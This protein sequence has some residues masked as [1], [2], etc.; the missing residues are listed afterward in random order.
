MEENVEHITLKNA[1]PEILVD[2]Q[3]I[4]SSFKPLPL[5]DV[6]HNSLITLINTAQH[7]ANRTAIDNTEE[8]I[9][10]VDFDVD[11]VSL[12]QASDNAI[13]LFKA[14]LDRMKTL[15]TTDEVEVKNNIKWSLDGVTAFDTATEDQGFDPLPNPPD[16]NSM[17]NIV[18]FVDACKTCRLSQPDQEEANHKLASALVSCVQNMGTTTD[19]MTP[20][21]ADNIQTYLA[22]KENDDATMARI[23]L[24]ML[25][26]KA[27]RPNLTTSKNRLF[28]IAYKP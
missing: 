12:N 25:T 1:S 14:Y 8:L 16:L 9:D 18:S 19:T 13:A 27:V 23:A 26:S 5:D 2:V 15:H 22:G 28:I 7:Q 24:W 10:T 3:S 20:E 4:L 11:S 21:Q 17:G 6:T